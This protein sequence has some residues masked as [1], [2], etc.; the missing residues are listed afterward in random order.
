MFDHEFDDQIFDSEAKKKLTKITN[1][2]KCIYLKK[3]ND[4]P[5]EEKS[6]DETQTD[7]NNTEPSS[8]AKGLGVEKC[9]AFI[10][11]Y[12]LIKS[13]KTMQATGGGSHKHFDL[14]QQELGVEMLKNDEMKSLV[15]GMIFLQDSVKDACFTFTE[16]EGRI[17]QEEEQ[18]VFPR[19]LV[20]IGSG[21]SIIKVKSN[22]EYERICGTM[23]GG[24]TL[25]GLSNLLLRV[26]DF[27]KIQELSKKGDNSKVD[28]LIKD[29]YDTKFDGL[30]DDTIA[31][32]FGKIASISTEDLKKRLDNSSDAKYK[33]ATTS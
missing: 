1:K 15:K 17:Y 29:L 22:E 16:A 30:E 24:G 5:E 11:K 13:K 6:K 12:D 33:V 31:S 3:W 9:I 19:I 26:N 18:G 14:F 7:S 20:S 10:K 27:T 32:S 25:V 21:V 28:N 23:I 4:N 2:D 8:A